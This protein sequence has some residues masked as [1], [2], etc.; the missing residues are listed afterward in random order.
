V[1]LEIPEGLVVFVVRAIA[2]GDCGEPEGGA[3]A[4]C[5]YIR[6]EVEFGYP[7]YVLLAGA[8][9]SRPL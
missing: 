1:G 3:Q 8:S 5:Q 4:L 6:V 2:R 9:G 7:L